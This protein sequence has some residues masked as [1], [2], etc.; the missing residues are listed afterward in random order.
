MNWIKKLL[1]LGCLLLI[2]SC[3][4]QKKKSVIGVTI[5]QQELNTKYKDASQSPLKKKD[6]R[7]FKKITSSGLNGNSVI[8][9][10]RTYESI[11]SKALP[12]R[13]NIVVSK[14]SIVK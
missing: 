12:D 11:G 8:M 6:L 10:R 4:S 9:G 1:F 14:N 5:Y 3:N 2:I 13:L 7:N